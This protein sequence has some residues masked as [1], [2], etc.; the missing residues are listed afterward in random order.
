MLFYTPRPHL[1]PQAPP[2]RVEVLV[3]CFCL[4]TDRRN[5]WSLL[6][7]LSP[8][9]QAMAMWRLGPAH[10]FDRAHPTGEGGARQRAGD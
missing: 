5:L 2:H 1:P 7:G 6:Y 8:L 4:I 10:V 3:V 9:E